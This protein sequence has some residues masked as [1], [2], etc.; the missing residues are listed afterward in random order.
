M[1]Q[2]PEPEPQQR[3]QL[4]LLA[5]GDSLTAGYHDSGCAF[6]PYSASLATALGCTVDVCGASGV[7]VYKLANSQIESESCIDVAGQ[8]YSGLGYLLKQRAAATDGLP[9][10]A[11]AL[12]MGGTNDLAAQWS[13]EEILQNLRTLHE[14]CW[15]HGLRTVALSI[16]PNM[17]TASTAASHAEYIHA[18]SELNRLI[19]EMAGSDERCVFVNSGLLVPWGAEG[20]WEPDGLHFSPAGSERLGRGVGELPEVR[21]FILADQQA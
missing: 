6:A 4:H 12:I 2:P 13:A 9:Q 11:A 14:C 18:F 3:P 7:Q 8:E 1:A 15:S 10:Y 20:C 5:Y 21:D 19:E 17:A 16:P